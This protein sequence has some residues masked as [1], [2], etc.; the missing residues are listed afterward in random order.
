M[1]GPAS[2]W[3]KAVRKFPY[4]WESKPSQFGEAD[5]QVL[6]NSS[7]WTFKEESIGAGASKYLDRVWWRSIFYS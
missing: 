4:C 7:R 2:A 5:W 3:H 6:E 1:P